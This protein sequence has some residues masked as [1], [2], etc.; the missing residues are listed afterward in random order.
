M[1]FTD[2]FWQ[3]R[4][5]ITPH[6]A[7]Q[8]HEVVVESAALTVYAPT[9]KLNHR[10]DTLN[11]PLLTVRYSAPLENVIRVQ[12]THHQ[13]GHGHRGLHPP[14]GNYRRAPP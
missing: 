1:K 12:I 5:G 2:G 8:A 11:L 13:D 14:G 7:A 6:Y 9:R 10:G 3:M 4:P